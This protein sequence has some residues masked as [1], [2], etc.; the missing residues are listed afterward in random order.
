MLGALIVYFWSSILEMA[1]KVWQYSVSQTRLAVQNCFIFGVN[2]LRVIPS[3]R[4]MEIDVILG[5]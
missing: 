1:S 5:G 2:V 3:L 4:S